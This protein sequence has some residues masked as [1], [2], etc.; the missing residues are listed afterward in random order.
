MEMDISPSAVKLRVLLNGLQPITMETVVEFPDGS[1]ALVFLEYKYLKNH[2][3]HCLRLTHDTKECPRLQKEEPLPKTTPLPPPLPAPSSSRGQRR[4]Y[5]TLEDN[6]VAPGSNSQSNRS[7]PNHR[8]SSH[9]LSSNK[10][11]SRE[12]F[13]SGRDIRPSS[14]FNSRRSA[15]V[16]TSQ[17]R[18]QLRDESS[19]SHS[20]IGPSASQH[21]Q[22]SQWREATPCS[23]NIPVEVS[24]STRARRPPLERSVNIY[25]Q[26]S[27]PI[28]VDK[29]TNRTLNLEEQNSPHPLA[30]TQDQIMADLREVT[31]QYTSCPDPTESAAR[32]VRVLQGETR[33]LMAETAAQ[34]LA[35][36]S[37][38]LP[39]VEHPEHSQFGSTS[40]FHPPLVEPTFP[41]IGQST[42]VKRG[43]GRPPIHKPNG[44]PASNKLLGAKS[45]KRNLTLGS[46]K[47]VAASKSGGSNS[48]QC[49]ASKVKA[50]NPRL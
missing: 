37:P 38:Q 28:L 12:R 19:N 46:P 20:R 2:C 14:N 34:I 44:K 35:A 26:S 21:K 30:Q 18:P 11:D 7:S 5:Y 10:G 13:I 6:F 27:L 42:S 36:N 50:S 43:R 40:A 47:K 22:T 3:H 29:P 49:K 45:Q 31:V 33:N 8:R 9:V 41:V 25:D 17:S 39:V 1:E 23:R 15:D 24:E 48:I 32:K 16:R 4:N